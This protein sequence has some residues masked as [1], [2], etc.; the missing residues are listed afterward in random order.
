MTTRALRP[1]L[2]CMTPKQLRA[3][4]DVDG[5]TQAEMAWKLGIDPRTMRRYCLGETRIPRVVGLAVELIVE[6]G[7][8]W[9]D[10]LE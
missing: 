4:L 8:Q 9:P 5:L 2:S 1:I 3:A 7:V 10:N 6:H